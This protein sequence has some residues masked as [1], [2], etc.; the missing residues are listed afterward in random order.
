MTQTS[1]GNVWT[2]GYD[3]RGR[4]VTA[5][6]KTSGGT[7]LESVTYTYDALDNRIGLDENGTQT[8]TLYDRGNPIMD[9]NSTGSLTMRYLW[10]PTGIVARQT[11][12]GT[13]SWY[14][15]DH[16]GTI[17]DIINNSGAIIDHVDF[18]AFG[19]VLGETSPTNGDRFTG[20][21][22]LERD[23]VTGL[24]L[25]VYREENPGTGRWDS[26]DP[27]NF[28][29][30]DANL[31]RYTGNSVSNRADLLGLFGDPVEMGGGGR[32]RKIKK[33]PRWRLGNDVNEQFEG[34]D[35]RKRKAQRR[36]PSRMGPTAADP[37]GD[38][39]GAKIPDQTS[40]QNDDKSRRRP[41]VYDPDANKTGFWH[42]LVE[43]I[44]PGVYEEPVW[45]CY[46][47]VWMDQ[48]G[49]VSES[50]PGGVISGSPAPMRGRPFRAPMRGSP[51][52][53]PTLRFPVI[54]IRPPGLAP[55]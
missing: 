33:G 24:N 46:D 37:N 42:G 21:A 5:V 53:A 48:A 14:L 35:D 55:L 27:A 17:R 50:P 34:L 11:S 6:E 43:T 28:S 1:T 25:A 23:S 54:T 39:A 31:Y 38:W 52:R 26:Q 47:G 32:R 4:M 22:M 10:G 18:S 30:Q 40:V 44:F 36:K 16:L 49:N 2:Y 41:I 20:F 19:T 3:F 8:W 29:G 15:A 51:L 7:T 9:F 12:G 45:R 13:V